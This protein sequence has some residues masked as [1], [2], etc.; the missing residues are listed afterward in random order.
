MTTPLA[1]R[2]SVDHGMLTEPNGGCYAPGEFCSS[3]EDGEHGIARD[4]KAITCEDDNGHWR[5]LDA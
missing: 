5:W 2:R 4:G 3:A 1:L